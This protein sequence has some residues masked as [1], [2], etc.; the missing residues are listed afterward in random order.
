MLIDRV[1]EILNLPITAVIGKLPTPYN[2]YTCF[3][4][5]SK[6]LEYQHL[7][8]TELSEFAKKRIEMKIPYSEAEEEI[9]RLI[10][11]K[12]QVFGLHGICTDGMTVIP[13]EST[14]FI[15]EKILSSYPFGTV[16]VPENAIITPLADNLNILIRKADFSCN[17]ERFAEV[18]GQ[19]KSQTI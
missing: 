18:F 19:P 7:L 8:V 15:S 5:F 4:P 17:S 10:M 11:Q 6:G 13:D 2:N 14:K 9:C 16:Y 3:L 1:I 12:K